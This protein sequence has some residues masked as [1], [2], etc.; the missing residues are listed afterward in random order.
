MVTQQSRYATSVG[1]INHFTMCKHV[2]TVLP[3]NNHPAGAPAL[4]RE[5]NYQPLPMNAEKVILYLLGI[6]VAAPWESSGGER[7]PCGEEIEGKY[8]WNSLEFLVSGPLS[9]PWLVRCCSPGGHLLR[10][11]EREREREGVKKEM[12]GCMELA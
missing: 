1:P 9:A 11:R 6:V 2:G 3:V 7:A 12:L 10:M 8:A 4:G 5:Y